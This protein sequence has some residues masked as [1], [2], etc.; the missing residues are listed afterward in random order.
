MW[1]ILEGARMAEVVSTDEF[2]DWYHA[3]DDGDARS[4]ARAV[5]RRDFS[6]RA[7]IQMKTHKWSDIKAERF[8]P[9]EIEKIRKEALRDLLEEDLRALREAAGVTQEELAEKVDVDQSQIS[10]LERQG[11]ARIS[12]LK[13]YVEALGGELQIVATLRGKVV[14]LP[15]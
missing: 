14:R 12:L 5:D 11:D 15:V 9:E 6:E 3:L 4:V 8:S 1:S 13:R 2:R 10:R 7:G